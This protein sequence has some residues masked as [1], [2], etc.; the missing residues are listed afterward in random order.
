MDGPSQPGMHVT[1]EEYLRL[2][3]EVRTKHELV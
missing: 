3:R 1:A 2:D